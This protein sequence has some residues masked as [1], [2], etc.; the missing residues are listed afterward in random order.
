MGI[1]SWERV[2]VSRGRAE[3]ERDTESE[4]GSRLWT[5]SIEPHAG[6]EP[7]NGEIMTRA[8]VGRLTDW[9]TQATLDKQITEKKFFYHEKFQ[10]Q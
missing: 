9:A 3:W 8:E 6:L 10:T 4:A 7:T 5:V 2:C 1:D